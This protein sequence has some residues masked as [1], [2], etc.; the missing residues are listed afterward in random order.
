[1]AESEDRMGAVRLGQGLDQGLFDVVW[2]GEMEA[3]F[4][5]GATIIAAS[6]GGT[7][8]GGEVPEGGDVGQVVQ[9]VQEARDEDVQVSQ[10]ARY[11]DLG[12]RA[13]RGLAALES[14][15]RRPLTGV[16]GGSRLLRPGVRLP[17]LE[18]RVLAGVRRAGEPG[19]LGH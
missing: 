10:S 17:R 5:P 16:H 15:P 12:P 1:M 11:G 8:K 19:S 4:A 14:F 13:D 3:D 7:L 2:Q 18:L 6:H 9:V